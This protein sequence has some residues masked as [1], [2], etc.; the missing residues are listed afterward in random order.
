MKED[1]ESE[2]GKRQHY[3]WLMPFKNVYQVK[4]KP[5][6][7]NENDILPLGVNDIDLEEINSSGKNILDD[8]ESS[9]F[10]TETEEEESQ[11]QD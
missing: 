5:L 11:A 6:P 8:Q 7:P 10:K 1:L 4:E 2:D 3:T 9:S